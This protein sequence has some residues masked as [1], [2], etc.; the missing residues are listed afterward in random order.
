MK[1]CSHEGESAISY[2]LYNQLVFPEDLLGIE[3]L[4]IS[5]NKIL[6]QRQKHAELVMKI[7]KMLQNACCCHKKFEKCW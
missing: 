2:L 7:Q 4:I 1:A 6:H 3:N 5:F